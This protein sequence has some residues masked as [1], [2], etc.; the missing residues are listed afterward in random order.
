MTDLQLKSFPGP[1]GADDQPHGVPGRPS[2]P[3]RFLVVGQILDQ[4]P[5]SGPLRVAPTHTR[6]VLQLPVLALWCLQSCA[7][8]C[9]GQLGLPH[10]CPHQPC[11]C[12]V[13]ERLSEWL[14]AACMYTEVWG[15]HCPRCS[16]LLSCVLLPHQS[17]LL[18]PELAT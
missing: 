18:A 5:R 17:L 6:P 2:R 10:S 16:S 9:P 15:P 14:S 3:T 7:G 1:P 4:R 8:L 11:D 12:R 13:E